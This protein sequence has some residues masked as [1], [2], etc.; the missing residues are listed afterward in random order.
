MTT[1]YVCNS[2]E[3]GWARLCFRNKQP[4]IGNNLKQQN[5]IS[6]SYHLFSTGQTEALP[7]ADLTPRPKHTEQPPPGML[8]PS[9]AEKRECGASHRG[10]ESFHLKT[11][12]ITSV[13]MS[14]AKASHMVMSTTGGIWRILHVPQRQSTEMLAKQY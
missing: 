1:S 3:P 6:H 10:S 9:A 14:M 11:T 8:P 7:S 5:C 12:A 4:P 2:L 13:P